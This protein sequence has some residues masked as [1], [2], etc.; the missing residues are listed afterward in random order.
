MNKF[1]LSIL[2]FFA[3]LP[4]LAAA[5]PSV[6]I[7]SPNGGQTFTAG[8]EVTITWD[9]T[10][11]DKVTL[12]YETGSTN[13]IATNVA[14]TNSYDWTVDI[15]NMMP[16]T[17]KDVKI[18]IIAY[19]TGVGSVQD[20]SDAA[21]TVRA[22]EKTQTPDKDESDTD[23]EKEQSGDESKAS[24]DLDD[25]E[26][27]STAWFNAGG[28][29]P[30]PYTKWALKTTDTTAELYGVVN[31]NGEEAEVWFYVYSF[32]DVPYTHVVPEPVTVP[33][34]KELIDV[35]QVITNLQPDTS[36]EFELQ[37]VNKYETV[38]IG[39]AY[40]FTTK[41]SAHSDAEKVEDEQKDTNDEHDD[42]EEVE[43]KSNNELLLQ[44]IE[45]LLKLIALLQAKVELME[46]AS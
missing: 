30:T 3:L 37:A 24:K 18:K 20:T 31:P 26:I 36:Y 34:V 15:G 39:H 11:V 22:T 1:H 41:E 32:D 21:F 17:E 16:G 8:D 40:G 2:S 44:Q 23:K 10:N 6:E 46:A 7:T 27:G 28:V 4:G 9:S 45:L 13:N 12:M 29:L 19:E 42:G 33:A 43:E 38:I 14:N 25:Y 35:K 5:A